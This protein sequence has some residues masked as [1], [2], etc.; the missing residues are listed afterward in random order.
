MGANCSCIKA[1]NNEEPQITVEKEEKGLRSESEVKLYRNDYII[2]LQS[3]LR[4][5]I[6]RKSR[7]EVL[8]GNSNSPCSIGSRENLQ[9][10]VGIV[11]D[12]SNTATLATERKIG[13]FLYPYEP[14]DGVPKVSK[15]PI[16]LENGA[17]YTG[18]WNLK[19]ERH[20]KG[21]QI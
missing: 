13:P 2:R 15:Q 19:L 17:I 3:I 6:A 9:E 11:P 20:G 14:D 1:F 10:I 4:G 8:R 18:E 16:K 12:Y 5:Y 7:K 21:I